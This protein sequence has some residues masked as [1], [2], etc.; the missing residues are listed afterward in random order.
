MLDIRRQTSGGFL[1]PIDQWS[2]LWSARVRYQQ[3]SDGQRRFFKLLELTPQLLA[4][5]TKLL[6][7]F[8]T[9]DKVTIRGDPKLHGYITLMG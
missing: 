6:Q 9:V 3:P 8:I 2:N 7:R 5:F 4:V 1:Q